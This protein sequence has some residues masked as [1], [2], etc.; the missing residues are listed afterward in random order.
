MVPEI[1]TPAVG[2]KVLPFVGTSGGGLLANHAVELLLP[3]V[4]ER[5][6]ASGDAVAMIFL[7]RLGFLGLR[8]ASS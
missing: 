5:H 3:G 1:I 7:R 2:A 4:E 6:V 8:A